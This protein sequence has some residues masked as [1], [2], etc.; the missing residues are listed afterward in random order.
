M[1][2]PLKY[3]QTLTLIVTGAIKPYSSHLV[4]RRST[5][6]AYRDL[7]L[8]SKDISYILKISSDLNP[9]SQGVF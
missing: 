9:I 6:Q 4:F 8:K 5:L 7:D 3:F 1:V 2:R